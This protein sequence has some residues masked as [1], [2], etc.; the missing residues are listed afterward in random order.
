MFVAH[1]VQ[2][3]VDV[4]SLVASSYEAEIQIKE[5]HV[6]RYAK[7]AETLAKFGEGDQLGERLSE[8][9]AGN[10]IDY[11]IVTKDGKPIHW[12]PKEGTL[13]ISGH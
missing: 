10:Y 11:F 2:S 4:R 7:L 6:Y 5:K 3:Y 9:V 1:A 12:E 8:A 13:D